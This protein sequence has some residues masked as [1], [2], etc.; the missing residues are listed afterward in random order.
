VLLVLL[1]GRY[2]RE[3][4]GE[5]A[6]ILG[7]AQWTWLERTLAASPAQLVVIVSGVQV[8]A[9]EHR[10]EKWAQY[11]RA[12]SRLLELIDRTHCAGVVFVSGDRHIAEI[13]RLDPSPA[14]YPLFDLTTSGMTH[15]YEAFTSEPNRLRLGEV[16]AGKNFGLI[17]IDWETASAELQVRD[18][19][20]AVRCLAQRSLAQPSK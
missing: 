9:S 4:P 1:D 19:R 20:G 11:P 15:S 6:D 16:Y 2:H 7:A 5:Q 17:V 8:L 13:S 3:A 18:E 10:F 12:R 14:G